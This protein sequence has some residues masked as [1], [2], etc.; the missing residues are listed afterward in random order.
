MAATKVNLDKVIRKMAICNIFWWGFCDRSFI[1]FSGV[2]K[3][4]AT[5]VDISRSVNIGR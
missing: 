2:K 3:C 1:P 5:G 4:F